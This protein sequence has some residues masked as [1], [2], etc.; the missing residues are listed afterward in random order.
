MKKLLLIFLLSEKI[1]L[2]KDFIISFDNAV[3]VTDITTNLP[4]S[5]AAKINDA[6]KKAK[7]Q[8]IAAKLLREGNY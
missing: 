4:I 3:F 5:N 1:S 6:R 8:F 2:S 7:E